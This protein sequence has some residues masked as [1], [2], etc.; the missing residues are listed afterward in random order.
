MTCILNR[1]QA[2][3]TL[4]GF[5]Y[6][7]FDLELWPW[8]LNVSSDIWHDTE[9]IMCQISWKLELQFSEIKMFIM[10]EKPTNK[11]ATALEQVINNQRKINNLMLLVNSVKNHKI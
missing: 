7:S 9:H 11:L 8:P 1:G 3:T 4:E 5:Q 10:N 2:I 6:D